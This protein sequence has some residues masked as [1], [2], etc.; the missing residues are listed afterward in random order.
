MRHETLVERV[1]GGGIGTCQDYKKGVEKT[2][3]G[4]LPC[5]VVEHLGGKVR[6]R[7]T[8]RHI[9]GGAERADREEV[10]TARITELHVHAA[11]TRLRGDVWL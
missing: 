5:H 8:H 3:L 1:N 9:V 4:A 10:P 7:G 11:L 6:I 2:T